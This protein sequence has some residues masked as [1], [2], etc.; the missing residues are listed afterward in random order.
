MAAQFIQTHQVSQAPIEIMEGIFFQGYEIEKYM[1]DSTNLVIVGL[2][3]GKRY[4]VK[5]FKIPH[6]LDKTNFISDIIKL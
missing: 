5:F 4:F 2:K 1:S 3:N 6:K